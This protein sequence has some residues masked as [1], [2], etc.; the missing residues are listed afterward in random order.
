MGELQIRSVCFGE[1]TYLVP[2]PGIVPW[3]HS[4]AAR[5]LFTVLSGSNWKEPRKAT[6]SAE[7]LTTDL[8]SSVECH[9]S[10]WVLIARLQYSEVPTGRVSWLGCFMAGHSTRS[11]P[12]QSIFKLC[13]AKCQWDWF[14]YECCSILV[15]TLYASPPPP[16]HTHTPYNLRKRQ[17]RCG[18]HSG[19]Q[20][21]VYVFVLRL[22]G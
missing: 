4:P 14:F 1:V 16:T 5:R 11:L 10:C 12:S 17:R 8:N 18:R 7:I 19:V 3:F 2:L 22:R 13:W 6:V 20:T 21:G 9:S 15:S